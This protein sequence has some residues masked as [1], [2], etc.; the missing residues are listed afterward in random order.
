MKVLSILF[1]FFSVMLVG[2]DSPTPTNNQR[3]LSSTSGDVELTFDL[4][5]LEQGEPEVVSQLNG[6]QLTASPMV[7]G[8][9]SA[10]T[11]RFVLKGP[12][13][14]AMLAPN[15]SYLLAVE[16]GTWDGSSKK[17][18]QVLFSNSEGASGTIV[19][20]EGTNVK[21]PAIVRLKRRWTDLDASSALPIEASDD[22]SATG[23]DKPNTTGP[24]KPTEPTKPIADVPP[25]ELKANQNFE[26]IANDGSTIPVTKLFT[27]EHLVIDIS[28]SGCGSCISMSEKHQQDTAFQ[29]TMNGDRC[30][31]LTIVPSAELVP[32]K[33]RFPAGS[34]VGDHTFGAKT[35]LG[36]I[37]QAFGLRLTATPTVFVIDR[38][39][40][41]VAQMVGGVPREVAQLC[42][43]KP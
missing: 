4:P 14:S 38:K 17:L 40:G 11:E 15:C 35:N 21:D 36:A 3:N 10:H 12:F 16:V 24:Q 42:A 7:A 32:W 25:A 30:N 20:L 27:A 31:Y 9:G 34:F 41:L 29:A 19:S 18:S 22:E 33:R 37:T 8:C 13:V 5:D 43:G 26:L 28:S 6:Y 2:C 23:G 1:T 39:G